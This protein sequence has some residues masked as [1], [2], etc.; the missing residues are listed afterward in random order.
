MRIRLFQPDDLPRLKEIMVE[1]FDGVS[2]DQSIESE[3][4][5]IN[6]HDWKWRKAR[7]LD[8]DVEREPEGIF[9]AE[10]DG[11]TIGFISAW[12]DFEAGVGNIPNISLTPDCRGKGYG[13]ILIEHVLDWFR[14]N[15][16]THARIE[17]LAQNAIGDHLYSSIGFREVSRQVHFAMELT[18]RKT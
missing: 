4:G 18:D 9:V 7:H 3:F 2:I 1:A 8:I 11:Q 17:T 15:G 14:E 5:L 16:L 12:R 10:V 13:R 6:G